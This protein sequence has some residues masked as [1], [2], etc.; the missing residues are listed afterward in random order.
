[1]HERLELVEAGEVEVVG[2][3]VEQQ[4]V[5]ARQEDGGEQGSRRLT[6][7][8][9]RHRLVELLLPR[10]AVEQPDRGTGLGGAGLEVGA[11]EGE[12]PVERGGVRVERVGIVGGSY[13]GYAALI[14]V[15]F[16][17]DVFA[18]AVDYVGVSDLVNVLRSMPPF[19][20]PGLVANWYR[21][22]G[23]PDVP[24]QHADMLARSPISH[25]D[26]IR[27]P[28]LVAQ[29]ANDSR[30]VKAE[31]DNIVAALREGGDRLEGEAVEA[32]GVAAGA[33]G[34]PVEVD[35][36]HPPGWSPVRAGKR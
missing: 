24:E 7:G 3:L 13:G 9:R 2:R 14:G 32:H 19:V 23:D 35:A 29:G 22:V 30:V 34:Q 18:A 26:A 20:R 17:P 28:L 33:E 10:R 5:V 31:S 12:E 16:T 1:M 15:T 36:A 25:V 6:P 4:D 8:Q 21:Y 11:A 27:T